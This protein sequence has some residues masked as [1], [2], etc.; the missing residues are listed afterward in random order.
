MRNKMTSCFTSTKLKEMFDPVLECIEG[1]VAKIDEYIEN[2]QLPVDN[3][4]LSGKCGNIV[5]VENS[6][7]SNLELRQPKL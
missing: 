4:T 1:Y 2:K 7:V 6:K 3:K 5:S